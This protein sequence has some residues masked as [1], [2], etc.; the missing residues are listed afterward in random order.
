LK[1][2]ILSFLFSLI[3]IA[4]LLHSS[5]YRHFLGANPNIG[6]N[7]NQTPLHKAASVGAL[8][9]LKLM[10]EVLYFF[11]FLSSLSHCLSSYH[12]I[13]FSSLKNTENPADLNIRDKDGHT[14][15]DIADIFNH[16]SSALYLWIKGTQFSVTKGVG[17]CDVVFVTVSFYWFIVTFV[18][19]IFLMET[20][21]LCSGL[22]A[23][24]WSRPW[25]LNCPS[26]RYHAAVCVL[27]TRI[28][29]MGGYGVTTFKRNTFAPRQDL[30]DLYMLDTGMFFD[31]F[32]DHKILSDERK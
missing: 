6:D 19:N 14:A 1:A 29:L 26:P 11:V 24:Q 18:F 13:P 20:F 16:S 25:M 27:G 12:D 17:T 30:N 32:V 23:L 28:F 3:F 31:T 9:C 7:L 15:F 8:D 21:H 10:I 5:L 22:N 2:G 4:S